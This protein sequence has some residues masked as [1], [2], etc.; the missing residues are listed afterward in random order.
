MKRIFAILGLAQMALLFTMA[1]VASAADAMNMGIC[2][3]E[4]LEIVGFSTENTG[5]KLAQEVADIK[6]TLE[7]TFSVVYE[8]G[9]CGSTNTSTGMLEKGD[10]TGVVLSEVAEVVSSATPST[11]SSTDRIVNVYQGV[12]CLLYNKENICYETRT[13]YTADMATCKTIE[14][15]TG[16]TLPEGKTNC[17]LRQWIIASTGMGLLKI[18]VKQIFTF[19]SMI[20]GAIAVGNI[21]LNG[22]RISMAGVSGDISEAKQK[23]TQSLSGIV[24]LFLSALILYSINPDFFG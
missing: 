11:D 10:C 17:S 4:K 2:N 15:G 5:E 18:Y 1:P 20:V 14:A 6:V 21:I 9:S 24:L 13:Y 3:L 12:C 8:P 22:I 23:I 16:T 7:D 19:G